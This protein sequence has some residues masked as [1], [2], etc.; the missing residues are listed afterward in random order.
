MIINWELTM[1]TSLHH[2]KDLFLQI[3]LSND[4]L[5]MDSFIHKNKGIPSSTLLWEA[6]F[7]TRSQAA[8][9]KESYDEDSDWVEA[10]DHLD[11]LLRD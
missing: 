3:G 5:D 9:L 8:F 6:D 4:S 7:W 2:L 11:A 1:D 10:V